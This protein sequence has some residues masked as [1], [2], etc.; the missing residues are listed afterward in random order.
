MGKS[1]DRKIKRE[2]N[3]RVAQQADALWEER[4]ARDEVED[5]ELFEFTRLSQKFDTTKTEI[6]SREF[7][8]KS[9][10]LLGVLKYYGSNNIKKEEE[11]T[12]ET[13][14]QQFRTENPALKE[15]ISQKPSEKPKSKEPSVDPKAKQ[16]AAETK[17]RLQKFDEKRKAD[18]T[19][20]T[21]E[22]VR[23]DSPA[24]N[25]NGMFSTVNAQE[26][27]EKK[28]PVSAFWRMLGY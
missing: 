1:Y 27:G 3:A 25:R 19:A 12:R 23:L 4:D 15:R 22:F 14:Y 2:H 16:H 8:K 26:H 24:T 9:R 18:A 20:E 17:R 11:K 5:D 13:L 21:D 28:E 7:Y 10:A 6:L